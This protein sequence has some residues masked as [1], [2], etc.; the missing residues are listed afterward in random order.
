MFSEQ[1]RTVIYFVQCVQVRSCGPTN[2]QIRV[3]KNKKRNVDRHRCLNDVH[4]L[5]A[6]YRTLAAVEFGFEEK[7]STFGRSLLP[8]VPKVTYPDKA[9][10]I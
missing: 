7:S 2:P 1:Y 9:V 6:S 3:Q 5:Y 10:N 8:G 4:R